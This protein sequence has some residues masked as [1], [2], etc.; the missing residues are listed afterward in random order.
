MGELKV[1]CTI[2]KRA[3]AALTDKHFVDASTTRDAKL[4]VALTDLGAG[5]SYQGEQVYVSEKGAA[6]VEKWREMNQM[7]GGFKLTVLQ[8]NGIRDWFWNYRE[9]DVEME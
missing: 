4:N 7:P 2:S 1:A 9:E 6:L 8:D 5:V 3:S